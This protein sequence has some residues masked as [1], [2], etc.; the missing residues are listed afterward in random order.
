MA[1]PDPTDHASTPGA[2]AAHVTEDQIWDVLRTVYDPEIPVNIVDLGLIYACRVTETGPATT[3]IEVDL[4]LTAPGCG[5]SE[6]LKEEIEQ[7]LGA[8][9][10]VQ[11]ARVHLVFEPPWDP[12]RMSEAARL[13][14]GLG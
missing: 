12:S 9:G 3:R 8:L 2:P 11:E 4:T 10:T 5:M 14:L 6:I 13:E 7:K 1:A